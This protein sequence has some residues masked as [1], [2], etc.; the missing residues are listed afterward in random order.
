MDADEAKLVFERKAAAVDPEVELPPLS[1]V[2][3]REGYGWIDFEGLQNTR[4]LGGL[5]TQD[6]RRVRRGLLLRS[7]S[8]HFGTEADLRRLQDEYDLRVVIDF[9]AERETVESPDPMELLPGVRYVPACVLDGEA[10]GIMQ[11]ERSR[12]VAQMMV[13]RGEVD[14]SKLTEVLYTHILLAKSALKG[15]RLFFDELLAC[16]TG[17]ALWHC[18]VGRDRCGMGSYLLETVLGV[19]EDEK[20]RDYLATNVYAPAE[21]TQIGP[22]GSHLLDAATA[23]VEGAYGGYEGYLKDGLGLTE[24][25]LGA[26][27]ARYLEG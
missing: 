23:A 22:A 14:R 6:G 27:R 8:L 18:F 9:R 7:G 5:L 3:G 16:E 21:L 24:G 19:P 13:E 2:P 4:D 1:A 10:F 17:A 15:Y 11:D 25:E 12:A 26:L 20:R